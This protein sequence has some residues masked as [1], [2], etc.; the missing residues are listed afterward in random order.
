MQKGPWWV[1]FYHAGSVKPITQERALTN[2]PIMLSLLSN[3][4]LRFR[5]CS[6][7]KSRSLDA[8]SSS[9]CFAAVMDGKRIR[10]IAAVAVQLLVFF[11]LLFAPRGPGHLSTLTPTNGQQRTAS[12]P[13]QFLVKV[14][15]PSAP[16]RRENLNSVCIVALFCLLTEPGCVLTLS[17]S[18]IFS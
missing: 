7:I 14:V 10:F 3:Q 17:T 6:S 2:Q 12:A 9:I 5:F 8:R 13:K 18:N 16:S 15:P 1:I 11:A 4:P